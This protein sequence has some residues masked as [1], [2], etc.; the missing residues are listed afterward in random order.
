MNDLVNNDDLIRIHP[1]DVRRNVVA[2]DVGSKICSISEQNLIY[3][4][5]HTNVYIEG[6]KIE[7]HY[8]WD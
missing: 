2:N 1:N 8:F 5:D 3:C 7:N 4:W 6:G